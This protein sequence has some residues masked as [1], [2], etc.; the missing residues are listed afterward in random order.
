MW[1]IHFVVK[2]K[3]TQ[4]CKKAILPHPLEKRIIV[5][6][7]LSMGKLKFRKD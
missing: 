3:L 5:I 6:P 1:I 4:Q 2:Q 7:I